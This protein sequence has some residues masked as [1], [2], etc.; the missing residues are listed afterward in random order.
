MA[1][2]TDLCCR[3]PAK[4]IYRIAVVSK[5]RARDRAWDLASL[6][7]LI[8]DEQFL[9]PICRVTEVANDGESSPLFGIDRRLADVL[10]V[11]QVKSGGQ[12]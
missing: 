9:P 6:V 12:C 1:L 5:H 8:D 3:N 4:L 11:H 7:A 10:T 2:A